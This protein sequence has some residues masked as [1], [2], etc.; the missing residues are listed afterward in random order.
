[1]LFVRLLLPTLACVLLAAHF[2]RAGALPLAALSAAL[3]L[4][5]AV[6]RAW[7]ARAMQVALVLGAFEWLHTLAEIAGARVA[8]GQPVLRLVLILMTVALFTGASAL[9]FRQPEVK[10]RFRLR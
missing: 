3:P 5:L 2:Y 10:A 8:T 4:L 7:A 1:M 6:P 9:V